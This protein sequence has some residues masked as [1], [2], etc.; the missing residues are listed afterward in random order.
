MSIV[1]QMGS[2]TRCIRLFCDGVRGGCESVGFGFYIGCN[3]RLICFGVYLTGETTSGS[4]QVP[5]VYMATGVLL[6][7]Q[8]VWVTLLRRI[9]VALTLL[10]LGGI[11]KSSGSS[12]GDALP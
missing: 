1:T 9:L 5:Q 3:C 11:M 10:V 8:R 2:W 4:D 6:S 7:L 12:V